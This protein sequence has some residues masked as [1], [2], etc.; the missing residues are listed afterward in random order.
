ME[1]LLELGKYLIAKSDPMLVI[2]MMILALWQHRTSKTLASHLNPDAKTNPYPHPQCRQE[3]LCFGSLIGQI[4]ENRHLA[5][6]NHDETRAQIKDLSD[7]INM[8]LQI[9]V[10][11]REDTDG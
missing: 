8:V 1:L 2:C 3:E 7:R 11:K 4:Q 9:A 5:A 6:S 10:D